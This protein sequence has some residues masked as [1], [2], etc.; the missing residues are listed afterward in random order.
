VTAAGT[1][2]SP[3]LEWRGQRRLNRH[4][5]TAVT[6]PQPTMLTARLPTE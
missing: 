4:I 3:R 2:D 6:A 5:Y 1:G